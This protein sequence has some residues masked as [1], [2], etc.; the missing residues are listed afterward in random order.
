MKKAI[1]FILLIAITGNFRQFEKV[2]TLTAGGPGRTTEVL[3]IFLYK[4][5]MGEAANMG[6]ANAVAFFMF[7]ILAIM[8]WLFIKL[9]GF[10]GRKD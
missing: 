7:I 5:G 8:C 1:L 2:Y 9:F 6:S 4:E 10:K 3:S